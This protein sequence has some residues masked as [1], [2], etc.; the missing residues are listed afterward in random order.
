MKKILQALAMYM[1]IYMCVCV[2]DAWHMLAH[3]N[4]TTAH[5]QKP[6]IWCEN[7]SKILQDWWIFVQFWHDAISPYPFS[8]TTVCISVEKWYCTCTELFI[9][10]WSRNSLLCMF[11]C[12]W[13]LFCFVCG[14]ESVT[15]FCFLPAWAAQF[16]FLFRSWAQDIFLRKISL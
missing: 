7:S 4:A 10:R 6:Q 15:C 12:F 11:S 9:V 8:I 3:R 13:F 2:S 16:N 1:Y 14:R 5:T